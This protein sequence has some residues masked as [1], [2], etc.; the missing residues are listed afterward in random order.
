MTVP[1]ITTQTKTR[2]KTQRNQW[3]RSPLSWSVMALIFAIVGRNSCGSSTVC[4]VK[5]P[6]KEF[7]TILTKSGRAGKSGSERATAAE[8]RLSSWIFMAPHSRFGS[9]SICGPL[10]FQSWPQKAQRWHGPWMCKFHA[11]QVMRLNA[12]LIHQKLWVSLSLEITAN[13]R[14]NEM[15]HSLFSDH[16]VILQRLALSL[17]G[18]SGLSRSVCIQ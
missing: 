14:K 13:L 11:V 9:I 6:W 3:Q 2:R 1:A 17:F 15:L 8:T 4:A 10:S 5:F 16:T 7:L 18:P 12:V